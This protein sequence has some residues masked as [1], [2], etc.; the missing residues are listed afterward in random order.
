[1]GLARKPRSERGS[2]PRQIFKSM[3]KLLLLISLLVL[4]LLVEAQA[5]MSASRIPL[6]I[7]YDSDANF[8]FSQMSPPP[9][10]T[11]KRLIDW[12]VRELKAFGIWYRLDR[13]F[14]FAAH[15]QQG[16]LLDWTKA[17]RSAT[18]VN[19]PTFTTDRGF[20]GNGTTSYINSN[21]NANSQGVNYSLNSAVI[22]AYVTGTAVDAGIVV[23]FSDA[24]AFSQFQPRSTGDIVVPRLNSGGS[25]TS[26]ST[27]ASGWWTID[28][29]SSA[30]FITYRNGASFSTHTT[31]S[32]A[33]SNFTSYIL[34]RN[35]A[36]TAGA[37]FSLQ[38]S[39]VLFGGT[40]TASQHYQL[41]RIIEYYMDSVQAGVQ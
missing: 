24:A 13:L 16:A 15:A 36:G 18:A 39:A 17:T 32:S 30:E 31:V 14:V 35:L 27:D 34:A 26:A 22:G 4:P 21:Y 23:G 33:V 25:T 19:S 28:R 20:T 41:N 12:T 29:A 2:R 37:F 3:K 11:R 6:S 7:A 8:L 9:D 5:P 10:A 40:L 1:M 38:T